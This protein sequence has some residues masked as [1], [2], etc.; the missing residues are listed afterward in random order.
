LAMGK[1]IGGEGEEREGGK[2]NLPGVVKE[3]RLE[4]PMGASKKR[5]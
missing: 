4:R 3:K 5:G 1:A 2:K